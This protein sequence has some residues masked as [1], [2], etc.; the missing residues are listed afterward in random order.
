MKLV[1]HM[2]TPVSRCM[3]PLVVHE[4]ARLDSL[5]LISVAFMVSALSACA[6]KSATDVNYIS[7]LVPSSN[8]VRF[9][10]DRNVVDSTTNWNGSSIT[11]R[12]KTYD[13]DEFY[14]D[15]R[16]K[17]HPFT[18]RLPFGGKDVRVSG[19]STVSLDSERVLVLGG[20]IMDYQ[21]RK[22]LSDVGIRGFEKPDVLANAW[23]VDKRNNRARAIVPMHVPCSDPN[24][25]TLKNGKILISG[26]FEKGDT[27][28]PIDSVEI[29]DPHTQTFSHIGKMNLPR[30]HH[31]VRQLASGLIL[32][33]AGQTNRQLSDS[34]G[35][36]TCTVEVLDLE[37]KSFTL[38]GSLRQA[39]RNAL[40]VPVGHD[41][42]L[43]CGG[44]NNTY[45]A[46]DSIEAEPVTTTELIESVNPNP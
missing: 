37:N 5:L 12:G 22:E 1:S 3:P 35:G 41:G 32:I 30:L 31:S 10:A 8:I 14:G 16:D 20:S 36:L 38:I 29:F 34:P 44:N 45:S 2:L 42:A 18:K 4:R 23:I 40:I 27:G 46:S 15:D 13:L 7:S 6:T 21:D 11:F 33:V 17:Y 39:R 24:L 25:S 26:G 43:I 19:Y 28:K 9:G